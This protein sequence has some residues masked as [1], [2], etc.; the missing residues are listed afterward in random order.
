MNSETV[1]V[2][3]QGDSDGF[4]ELPVLTLHHVVG[5]VVV[6]PDE[7][8]EYGKFASTTFTVWELYCPAGADITATDRVKVRGLMWD[9]RGEPS[10]WRS[11]F[12]SWVPGLKVVV[13]RTVG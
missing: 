7:T 12:S 5:G 6:A 3:R 13:T 11:P 4:D 8:D 10:E 9:V 2:W 1:E